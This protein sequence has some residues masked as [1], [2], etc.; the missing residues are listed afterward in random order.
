MTTTTRDLSVSKSNSEPLNMM[1]DFEVYVTI[2]THE[3]ER[4]QVN[5]DPL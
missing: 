4:G 2:A 5:L 1:H 3:L